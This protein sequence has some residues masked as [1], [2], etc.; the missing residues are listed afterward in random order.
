MPHTEG[1]YQQDLAF[2]DGLFIPNLSEIFTSGANPATQTR[3]GV[4]DFSLNQASSQTSNYSV[5][6]LGSNLFRSGFGEDLQE[7]F[8]GTGIAA[9][10]QPQFYRPDLGILLQANSAQLN[11]R[12]ALKT[13]GLK[14]RGV[15]VN[16]FVGAVALTSIVCRIDR[17]IFVDGVAISVTNVL[18]SAA[19]GL[20]TTNA[21]T[22]HV[23]TVNFPS[24]LVYE[25][26][27]WEELW[28]EMTVV[29]PAGGTFRL[30]GVESLIDFNYN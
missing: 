24:P 8:G 7:Q 14:F 26:T 10:A 1:R 22:N 23:I 5:N 9:S 4:G 20:V 29:T 21:T 17:S 18:A 19:N 12:T 30:Y 25:I 27:D 3:N 13:K 15:K 6:L 11:P 28:F 2:T 16:Y